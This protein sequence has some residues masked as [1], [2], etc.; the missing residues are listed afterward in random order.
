MAS[1]KKEKK[2][3]SQEATYFKRSKN[4][5][6]VEKLKPLEGK[7]K[8]VKALLK[9]LGGIPIASDKEL[10]ALLT[11]IATGVIEDRFGMEI[12][13]ADRLKAIE[14]L[15]QLTKKD[16]SANQD[17]NPDNSYAVEVIGLLKARKV[18]G[19]DDDEN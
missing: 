8:E 17:G 13:I 19:I 4:Q 12:S 18:E 1:V 6:K 15:A 5:N 7:G 16:E 10:T 2:E 11:L 9:R 14:Q 3:K